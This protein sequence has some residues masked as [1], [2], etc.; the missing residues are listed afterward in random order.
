MSKGIIKISELVNYIKNRLDSDIYLQNIVVQGEISNF[1]NHRSGHWY[2]TLKDDKARMSCVMFKSNA[3]K[4]KFIPKDGDKVLIKCNTSL[5]LASGQLQLY[6]TNIKIDGLGDLYLQFEEL[7]NKLNN[8]G[9]FDIKY[10]KDI[11]KYPKIIGL[12]T[13]R[14][15]AAREDVIT[16]I[17]R[18]WPIATIKEIPVLVQGEGSSEQLINA[19]KQIDEIKVDVVLIVR[20]GGSIEDLW[21]FNNETLAREIF[22]MKTPI[23]SGVGHE[24]DVTIV[25]Y[26]VDK[27]AAT[28]TAAAELAT[29]NI[30]EVKAN[31]N[32]LKDRIITSMK[33]NI[34][35]NKMLLN[36]FKSSYVFTNPI[37][38]Y[39]QRQLQLDM[40]SRQ[41]FLIH[42]ILEKKKSELS[43]ITNEFKNIIF[44]MIN[45][46]DKKIKISENSIKTSISHSIKLKNEKVLKHIQLLDAYSPLKV[47]QRGYS[48]TFKD[49]KVINS[50]KNIEVNDDLNIILNDGEI[51]VNVRKV[52]YGRK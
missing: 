23:I 8:E 41:L 17:S 40:L 13:G 36:K 18:R 51:N 27:R 24:I 31:I 21:S 33:N 45:Q 52:K 19:I 16:T 6:V 38:L 1:I 46:Y 22:K 37:K 14:S 15:T 43:I 44:D 47:M 7:K 11:P 10:K 35:N 26:V 12:I 30:H 28:P 42:P 9:L 49:D 20:G 4:I 50:V 29:P 5:F 2:F 25:D 3:S 48:V 32:N 39:E 34:D